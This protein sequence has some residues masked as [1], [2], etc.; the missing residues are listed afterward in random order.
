MISLK[1]F[2]AGHDIASV[3]VE[4]SAFQERAVGKRCFSLPQD[5]SHWLRNS[6]FPFLSSSLICQDTPDGKRFVGHKNNTTAILIMWCVNRLIYGTVVELY[7]LLYSSL[8]LSIWV[9][10]CLY[11]VRCWLAWGW[12][13]CKKKC[14]NR[15]VRWYNN[16]NYF[17]SKNFKRGHIATSLLS[18]YGLVA[19]LRI[20]HIS[21]PIV[22]FLNTSLWP[23]HTKNWTNWQRQS[24]NSRDVPKVRDASFCMAARCRSI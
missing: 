3:N 8:L 16:Q 1:C 10:P 15:I 4:S 9:T 14:N 24:D 6:L 17:S 2:T 19:S 13:L 12:N 20:F 11:C 18:S 5:H 22:D 21:A 7:V 23:P